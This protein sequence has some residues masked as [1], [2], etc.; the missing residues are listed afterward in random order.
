MQFV[1]FKT[2]KPAKSGVYHGQHGV[3]DTPCLIKFQNN[4]VER[5]VFDGGTLYF[6]SRSLDT[7]PLKW[8]KDGNN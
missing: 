3:L 5:I 6:G 1:D 2:E 7:E 8:L 4:R